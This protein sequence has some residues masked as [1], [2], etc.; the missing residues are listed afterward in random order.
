MKYII[1]DKERTIKN[2]TLKYFNISKEDFDGKSRKRHLVKAR[3]LFTFYLNQHYLSKRMPLEKIG[4]LIGNRSHST[5]INYLKNMEDDI[6]LTFITNNSIYIDDYFEYE[7]WMYKMNGELTYYEPSTKHISLAD[8]KLNVFKDKIHS[9]LV[10]YKGKVINETLI[11][12][13][14]KQ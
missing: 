5:I 2:N 3:M 9:K 1:R 14:L 4:Y 10:E 8:R 7:K 6:D 11:K 12:K 13:I